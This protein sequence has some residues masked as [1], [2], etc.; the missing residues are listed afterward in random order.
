MHDLKEYLL[1]LFILLE[2]LCPTGGDQFDTHQQAFD[3]SYLLK[4]DKRTNMISRIK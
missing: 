4:K 1:F 2:I 3:K